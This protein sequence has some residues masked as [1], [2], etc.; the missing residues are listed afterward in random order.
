MRIFTNQC[1][2]CQQTL[3]RVCNSHDLFL[4]SVGC[5]PHTYRLSLAPDNI[6]IMIL[7]F[8]KSSKTL[9]DAFFLW[10]GDIDRC[11]PKLRRVLEVMCQLHFDLAKKT[12]LAHTTIWEPSHY[13]HGWS[14]VRQRRKWPTGELL[15]PEK[16][17]KLKRK[18]KWRLP[19]KSC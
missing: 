9:L 5:D 13:N 11:N 14:V 16:S 12:M 2:E 6:P 3:S 8:E 7:R 10:D 1:D 17:P 4:E 19:W 15:P 18:R